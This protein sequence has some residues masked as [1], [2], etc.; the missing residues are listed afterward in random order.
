MVSSLPQ[1][2]SN[3]ISSS[4]GSAPRISTVRDL[5]YRWGG[6][7]AGGRKSG[8]DPP[9]GTSIFIGDSVCRGHLLLPSL[10]VWLVK[11]LVGYWQKCFVIKDDSA[12]GSFNMSLFLLLLQNLCLFTCT[13]G[14]WET[15]LAKRSVSGRITD[16]FMVA[17]R[18][19]VR[20]WF[21]CSP[22]WGLL[23]Q[24][25]FKYLRPVI[26]EQGCSQWCFP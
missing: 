20:N 13:G 16:L 12:L 14:E 3:L 2:L 11:I 6:Q 10:C 25:A 19:F 21:Y 18:I 15:Q 22:Q 5:R 26:P 8:H 9:G 4:L 17:S 1:T 23:T 24:S 7:F